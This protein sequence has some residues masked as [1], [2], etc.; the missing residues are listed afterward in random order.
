MSKGA[1]EGKRGGGMEGWCERGSEEGRRKGRRE[2][3]DGEERESPTASGG[4]VK[5]ETMEYKGGVRENART[6]T[7]GWPDLPAIQA[8]TKQAMFPAIMLRSAIFATS[9]VGHPRKYLVALKLHSVHG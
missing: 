5:K 4:G 3:V 7:L 8:V 2:R 9:P 6:G 1:M